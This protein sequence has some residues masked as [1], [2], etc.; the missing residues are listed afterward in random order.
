M[1][2]DCYEKYLKCTKSNMNE[3]LWA[4][5]ILLLKDA[6]LDLIATTWWSTAGNIRPSGSKTIQKK[7]VLR[8]HTPEPE[9]KHGTAG[10]RTRSGESKRESTTG[11][12]DEAAAATGREGEELQPG[13]GGGR[14][15]GP[16]ASCAHPHGLGHHGPPCSAPPRTP[17]QCQA[18]R[19][20]SPVPGAGGGTRPL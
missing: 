2:L 9:T 7:E 19:N 18:G 20:G 5:H 12:R 3:I 8:G 17:A 1:H 6:L 16:C 4:P 15:E 14:E 13:K 11:V 10:H